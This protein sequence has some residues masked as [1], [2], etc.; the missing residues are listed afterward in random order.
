M[1]E[2]LSVAG[3]WFSAGNVTV[4]ADEEGRFTVPGVPGVPAGTIRLRA[5]VYEKR[6]TSAGRRYTVAYKVD[7]AVE[8]HGPAELRIT[9]RSQT[10]SSPPS[11]VEIISHTAVPAV[12]PRDRRLSDRPGLAIPENARFR[13]IN[14]IRYEDV[15]HS[16]PSLQE[17]IEKCFASV[18]TGLRAEFYCH[19]RAYTRRP[20]WSS[21]DADA[22]KI[23]ELHIDGDVWFVDE[24]SGYAALVLPDYALSDYGYSAW[25]YAVTA[26]DI[27]PERAAIVLPQTDQTG[28]IDLAGLLDE[29]DIEII[30]RDAANSAG[31]DHWEN[32]ARF[33]GFNPLETCGEQLDGRPIVIEAMDAETVTYRRATAH[34]LWSVYDGGERPPLDAHDDITINWR[35]AYGADGRLLLLPVP[36]K[37]C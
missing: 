20:V 18:K 22:R 35:E 32:R 3:V 36:G 6:Y 17:A 10:T 14:L 15:S 7:E 33:L 23:G 11:N 27:T 19:A 26:L 29:T 34:D 8:L 4:V 16:I 1:P 25:G 28:W 21:S 9:M 12:S 31:Y 37:E 24:Q 30:R 5:A 2:H 13:L